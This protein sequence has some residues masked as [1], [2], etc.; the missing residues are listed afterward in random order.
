MNYDIPI[1]GYLRLLKIGTLGL[2]PYYLL[3]QSRNNNRIHGVF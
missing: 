1:A 2:Q 3:N